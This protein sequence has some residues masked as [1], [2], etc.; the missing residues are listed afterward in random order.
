[1]LISSPI[2]GNIFIRLIVVNIGHGHGISF[3]LDAWSGMG[4]L[5][6]RFQSLY[7]LSR[8]KDIEVSSQ[9]RGG[10]VTDPPFSWN[11]RLRIS[12][13]EQFAAL[14]AEIA[15]F[16]CSADS[17][18]VVIWRSR[19]DEFRCR[20]ITTHFQSSIAVNG[21][22]LQGNILFPDFWKWHYPPRIK[23]FTWLIIRDRISSNASLVSRGILDPGLIDCLIC[24]CEE[25][26]IHI[27]C[28]CRFAWRFW[29]LL[30]SKCG[31]LWVS[32]PNIFQFFGLWSSF[33]RA[34]F[35]E[36][37]RLIWLFGIWELWKLRNNRVFNN[38][39]SSPD[40]LAYLC[41]CKAVQFYSSL[42]PQFSYCGNDVFRCL[43]NF[44]T[45]L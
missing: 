12:E 26:S 25:T 11:R 4:P 40:N 33:T 8:T 3:W 7:N 2:Y 32:P 35:K 28:H 22:F 29:S 13:Q 18:N 14:V 31:I 24:K 10:T 17:R 39:E 23:F 37:W 6:I 42:H 27:V 1:M 30:L 36:L 44:V 38:V 16:S 9:L 34:R 43:D 5:A 41:V 45:Q 19:A 21:S 15:E 20:D